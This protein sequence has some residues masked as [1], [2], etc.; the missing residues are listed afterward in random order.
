LDLSFIVQRSFSD[1]FGNAINAD[2]GLLQ[3]AFVLILTYAALMLSK[4]DEG[5]VGSRVAV[6]FSGIVAIGTYC[7]SQIPPTVCRYKTDTFGY[8]S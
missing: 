3:A 1:E 8:L 7:I 6:T 2:L 4:W 5:C